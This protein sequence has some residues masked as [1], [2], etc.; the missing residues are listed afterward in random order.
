MPHLPTL[1]LHG[2]RDARSSF[3]ERLARL[4]VRLTDAE[5]DVELVLSGPLPV[6]VCPIL[7]LARTG[8]VEPYLQ[9]RDGLVT[10]VLDEEAH[11]VELASR[12]RR[13]RR[14][15]QP[16]GDDEL[17]RQLDL[18]G[19]LASTPDLPRL[20]AE[21]VRRLA[22]AVGVQRCS[23]VLVD[24]D[25][26]AR[27][28]VVAS[29]DVATPLAVPVAL[30]DYPEILEARRTGRPVL[31]A[32]AAHDPLLERVARKLS[33][34]GVGAVACFPLRAHG[35]F[36][37]ALMLRTREPMHEGRDLGLVATVAGAAAIAVQHAA[38]AEAAR[39][40]AVRESARYEAFVSQLS[41]GVAVLGP[42]LSVAL[43]NPAGALLL[44][45]GEGWRGRGL[46]ELADPV[47]P[48]AA[49]LL[50]R[51]LRRG[52][53]VHSADLEVR[54]PDGGR[55]VLA[56]SASPLHGGEEARSIVAFRDVTEER[57]TAD[58]LRRT[59]DFLG[60]LIDA[61]T[62][63]IVASDL[64]GRILVFNRAA[65]L[66]LGVEAGEA[67]ERW[68]V[69]ELFADGQAPEVMRRLRASADGRVT[70]LRCLARTRGGEAV[71]VELSAAL[72]RAGG[73]DEAL[74]GLFRDLRDRDRIE[75]VLARAQDRLA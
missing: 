65:E 25:D 55:R 22:E 43:L 54:H 14:A 58:E 74:L 52:A 63:A 70:G 72:V 21:V 37:G 56:L 44:G 17:E 53:R 1:R 35:R 36:L 33:A 23:L 10:D 59:R 42:D 50:A 30:A 18:M 5:P 64:S 29:S 11:D 57:A 20:L 40:A 16:Q 69:A 38:F 32:D 48:A 27:G 49:L 31:A 46:L 71:P 62:D 9:F 26:P 60:R 2:D 3:I 13:A 12:L 51:E 28:R 19:E 15:G 47:D 24:D 68:T 61:S 34:A 73:R 41:D 67:R 6:T 4:G 45:A 39:E 8:E 75:A 7:R 66:L